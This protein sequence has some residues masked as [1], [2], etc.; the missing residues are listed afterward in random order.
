MRKK[1]P[2]SLCNCL[3]CKCKISITWRSFVSQSSPDGFFS[4][5]FKYPRPPVCLL[6]N[7]FFGG[8][9]ARQPEKKNKWSPGIG[10]SP[11]EGE[12]LT[13]AKT[14]PDFHCKW[15]YASIGAQGPTS[16]FEGRERDRRRRCRCSPLCEKNLQCF[17]YCG[18]NLL[19]GYTTVVP[20]LRNCRLYGTRPVRWKMEIRQAEDQ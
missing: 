3:K 19:F 8:G 1:C 12:P 14:T 15:Y 11:K 7:P 5:W 9:V 17:G 18:V 10:G 13:P 6:L 2:R 4:A 20:F 16:G